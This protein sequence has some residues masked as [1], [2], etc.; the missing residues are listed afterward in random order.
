[1]KIKGWKFNTIDRNTED[2]KM[3]KDAVILEKKKDFFSPKN[4]L[5][6]VHTVS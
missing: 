2:N 6:L 3:L 5:P 4:S 1:L